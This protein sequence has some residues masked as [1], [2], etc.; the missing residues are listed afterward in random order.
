MDHGTRSIKSKHFV[1]VVG[2]LQPELRRQRL[3]LMQRTERLR[4]I[5]SPD[6]DLPVIV[7]RRNIR[8]T[9]QLVTPEIG[10]D[11]NDKTE[12]SL[13]LFNIFDEELL[14]MHFRLTN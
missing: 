10:H 13:L 6:K 8:E 12:Q 14:L 5:W 2:Y 1:G 4:I 3:Q 7:F 9:F 11:L